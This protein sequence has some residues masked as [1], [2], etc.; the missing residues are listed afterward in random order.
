VDPVE[1]LELLPVLRIDTRQLGLLLIEAGSGRFR[2]HSEIDHGVSLL[3]EVRLGDGIRKGEELGRLY[4]R[5]ADEDLAG[6]FEE[7][8]ILGETGEAPELIP[9]RVG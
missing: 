3:V 9:E 4:L 2:P 6:R 8:F 1:R 5:R 7:C